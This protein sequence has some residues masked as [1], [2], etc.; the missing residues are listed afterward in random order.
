MQLNVK[1]YKITW[2]SIIC[3]ALPGILLLY[4]HILT[5]T[6]LN[7]NRCGLFLGFWLGIFAIHKTWTS[8]A[9]WWRIDDK[10]GTLAYPVWCIVWVVQTQLFA[11]NSNRGRKVSPEKLKKFTF[12]EI[13]ARKVEKIEKFEK[14]KSSHSRRFLLEKSKNSKNSKS[15][16][17]E[18]FE[19]FKKVEK[20][21]SRKLFDFLAFCEKFC[22]FRAVRLP[23]RR[24]LSHFQ[25]HPFTATAQQF[26]N[27]V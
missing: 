9:F 24:A 20:S 22:N 18:K 23:A 1:L 3:V 14:S 25:T 19:K 26:S 21:K 16:K 13:S 15:R 10:T 27:P 8:L 6:H 7:P 4:L 2:Y 17:V 11:E 5:T 12:Q